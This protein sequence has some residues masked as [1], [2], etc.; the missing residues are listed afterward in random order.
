MLEMRF[1]PERGPSFNR[2]S[3][4]GRSTTNVGAWGVEG[5]VKA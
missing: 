4:V 2:R 1:A 3:P 5:E